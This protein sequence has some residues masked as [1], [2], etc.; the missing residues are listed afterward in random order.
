GGDPLPEGSYTLRYNA[1]D[2]AGNISQTKTFDF[3]ID[4]TAP[5]APTIVFPAEDTYFKTAPILNDWTDVTDPSGIDYYRIEYQ[6]D[7]G[8]AFSAGPYRTTT[9]S[10]RN[11]TPAL[12]E[13]GGI[14]FRVQAFD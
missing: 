10:Q 5:A 4:N 6:Y 11:H 12:S 7:D 8:H 13:Q 2:L 14:K 1:S 9:A 3:T